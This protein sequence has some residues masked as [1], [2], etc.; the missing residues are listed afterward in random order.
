MTYY[1]Y[2]LMGIFA[3]P[4]VIFVILLAALIKNLKLFASLRKMGGKSSKYYE[5]MAGESSSPISRS[6]GGIFQPRG[7]KVNE[8]PEEVYKR[9]KKLNTALFVSLGVCFIMPSIYNTVV[10][11]LSLKNP[12]LSKSLGVKFRRLKRNIPMYPAITLNEMISKGARVEEIAEAL[13]LGADV[14]ERDKDTFTTPFLNAAAW[15]GP[16]EMTFLLEHGARLDDK[17]RFNNTALN[18]AAS[19]YKLENVRFLI[20]KGLD[21]NAPGYAGY[22]PLVSLLHNWNTMQRGYEQL[23]LEGRRLTA[24]G[25][26]SKKWDENRIRSLINYLIE[27]KAETNIPDA[28]GNTAV[29]LSLGTE[30][31]AAVKALDEENTKKRNSGMMVISEETQA[32]N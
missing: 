2:A 14:N 28:R 3:I 25:A 26:R 13:R 24:N 18:K 17:D 6:E 21:L 30:F 7:K 31:E 23:R 15:A 10:F 5:K 12:E 16:D 9:I 29:S 8:T 19:W 22:T 4:Y 20:G 11:S 1:K 32:E 27:Q